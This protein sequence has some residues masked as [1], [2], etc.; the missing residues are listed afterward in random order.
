MVLLLLALLGLILGQWFPQGFAPTTGRLR[1]SL[2]VTTRPSPAGL[3]L[4]SLRL[5]LKMCMGICD[6]VH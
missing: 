2:D 1:P 4:L 3:S 5:V 6:N